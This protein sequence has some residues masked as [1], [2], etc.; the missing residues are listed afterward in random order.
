MEQCPKCKSKDLGV[1][2]KGTSCLCDRDF[3]H[4]QRGGVEKIVVKFKCKKCG[5]EFLAQH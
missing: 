1:I 4:G 5:E 3:C 2:D